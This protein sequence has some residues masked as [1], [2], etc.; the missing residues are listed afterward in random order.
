MTTPLQP[1]HN[2]PATSVSSVFNPRFTLGGLPPNLEIISKD[3]IHFHIHTHRLLAASTNAFGGLQLQSRGILTLPE[4]AVSLNI[5]FH[6]MY[7]MSV[8]PHIPPLESTEAALDVLIKYGLPISQLA[9][10]PTLPL[11]DLLRSYAPYYPIESYAL[12]AHHRLE[13]L[14]VVI[15]SHLLAYDV[16]RISDELCVKMGPIYF[17]R[18]VNLQ[19]SRIDALRNI[20]LRPPEMHPVTL[21]CNEENQRELTRA[22]A[23]ANAEM[24][25]SALPNISVSALEST[26]TNAAEAVSCPECRAMLRQRIQEV[27]SQWSMVK[28]CAASLYLPAHP[29]THYR[30]TDDDMTS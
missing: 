24:V 23:F 21:I 5:A 10:T 11:F 6:V 2:T 28:V 30:A 13:S 27:I 18:L 1:A 8:L 14:A 9:A 12:V 26:F 22:W 7:G 25:W 29:P 15:S 16:S 4:T 3:G 17:K 19:Q 20:V